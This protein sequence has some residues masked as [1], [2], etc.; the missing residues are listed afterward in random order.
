MKSLT[1][2]VLVACIVGSVGLLA[3]EH[4]LAA[5]ALFRV[6]RTFLGAPFPPVTTPGGAGRTEI[7]VEPYKPYSRTLSSK[8]GTMGPGT[9]TSLPPGYATVSPGNPIGAK[10]TLPR[11]FIDYQGTITLFPSTAFTGYLSRSVLDYVNGQARFGPNNPY[12]ATTPTTVTFH[13][14]GRYPLISTTTMGRKVY[15]TTHGG[16]FG[17]SRNG[18]LKIDPGPNRFGGTMR[19]LHSPAADYYQ[20]ISYF[21]PLLFKGEGSFGCTKMGVDCTEGFET[22]LGEATSSGMVFRFLLTDGTPYYWGTTMTP[23]MEG[24]TTTFKVYKHAK[25]T[26]PVVS[27][28]YYLH[29]NA[30]F[31]TGKVSAFN[32][33]GQTSG[34]AVH[35][36]STGYDKSLGGVDL[37]L[38]RTYTTVD[39]KGKGKTYY[40]TKKYYTKLTG[41]T[42]AVSLVKPRLTHV[43][44]IPRLA[45]DP[46]FSN[47]QANRVQIMRVFFLPEPGSLLLIASGIAGIA[48]LALLR[49]R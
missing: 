42:R 26:P 49:R 17:F 11:S 38:T 30:P 41:V 3:A 16:L 34:Y 40:Q 33:V 46:V 13:N 21:N 31:T 28:N 7:Y 5:K 20:Y 18:Y 43:Y 45:S 14:Q 27:K 8:G 37:T 24:G 2:R 22:E 10:F 19:Y 36:V 44:Q 6:Q 9:G 39:Y 32:D 35:P 29:L 1:S 23:T 25:V 47:Y 48:G 4:A 12:G 15:T